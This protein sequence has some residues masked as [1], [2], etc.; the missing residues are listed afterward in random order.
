[1]KLLELTLETPEENLA[2]DEALLEQAEAGNHPVEMLR[3][4]ESPEYVVVLG[5]S[6]DASAEVNLPACRERGIPV[7]RRSSGG[8]TVLI[9]P[10][11]LMYAVV[12]SYQCH[13][14]LRMIEKAHEF[15]LEHLRRAIAS[16]VA[17]VVASGTSDLTLDLRKCSGNSLRC[18]QRHL[19]YHGTVVYDLSTAV[20]AEC[21]G[22]PPRQPAYRQGRVHQDFVANIPIDPVVL[23]STLAGV[24]GADS[25]LHDP[26]LNETRRI[27]AA[28]YSQANWRIETG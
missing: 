20:M 4:W 1:M 28:R 6:S 15:V 13:P 25:P 9:G 27:A 24:W 10:G 21:L 23:R 26:P 18:R 17:D 16:Q 5:R 19:L 3:L 2:L 11:C 7:L 14:Q 8:T 22:T 12:L